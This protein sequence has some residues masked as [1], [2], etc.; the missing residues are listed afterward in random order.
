MKVV[1][2]VPTLTKP[3]DATLNA[4]EEAIPALDR[5]G[6]VHSL[7]AE[8]GCPY[9]SCAR[10]ILMRKAF[11][12][13]ADAIVFLDHDVSFRPED[14]VKLIKAP[15]DVVAGTYRFK[16]VEEEYMGALVDVEDHRPI[17]REDGCIKADRVPAG[18]LKITRAAVE[19]FKRCFPHL[20]FKDRDG[21]ESVD[22]FN[23]GAHDGLWYGEDYAFCRNW[24]SIGGEIWLVPDLNIDHHHGEVAYRGNFHEFMLRQ[25]GGSNEHQQL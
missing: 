20:I 12:A 10:A 8:I 18:F 21:F 13:D 15:G 9:I 14:L 6:I 3:H 11:E 7:V 4:I 23:H 19:K 1:I 16:K 17:V 5:A 25:P 22:L 2:G 24:V